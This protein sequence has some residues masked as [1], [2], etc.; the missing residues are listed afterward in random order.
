VLLCPS[1]WWKA[2]QG[3]EK[4]PPE[5]R[6]QESARGF[7]S[8]KTDTTDTTDI[9]TD[10]SDITTDTTSLVKDEE[11]VPEAVS[12]ESEIKSKK[13]YILFLGNLALNTTEEAILEHFSKRGVVISQL[14]LLTHKDT[15]KPRGCAF[16]EFSNDRSLKNALKFHRSKLNGKTINIEVTCGGGGCGQGR[17]QK[18]SSRI[19]QQRRDKARKTTS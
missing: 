13:R 5:P 2:Q 1:R 11:P 8:V 18:I 19:Q 6:V 15:G 14:R 3:R 9:P 10:T 17:R 12:Q 16:A 4:S 7:R